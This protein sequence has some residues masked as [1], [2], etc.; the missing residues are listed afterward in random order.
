MDRTGQVKPLAKVV[1]THATA[2]K[3]S[4]QYISGL[5]TDAAENV[6]VADYATRVVKKVNRYRKV[7]VFHAA[8][9]QWSPVGT[10]MGRNGDFWLVEC[11]P[12]SEVLVAKI[13]KDGTRTIY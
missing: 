6:Y 1:G 8:R 13:S 9:A 10:L 4:D 11:S 3:N 7:S 2:Q 5:S 12:T